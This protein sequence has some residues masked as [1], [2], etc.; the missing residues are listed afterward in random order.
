LRPTARSLKLYLSAE[1]NLVTRYQY[2]LPILSLPK[3]P[4]VLIELTAGHRRRKTVGSSVDLLSFLLDVVVVMT[5]T[6][7]LSCSTIKLYLDC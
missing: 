4:I 1:E 3:I 6:L 5:V 2:Y 7:R